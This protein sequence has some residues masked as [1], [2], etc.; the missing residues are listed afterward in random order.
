MNV[1]PLLSGLLPLLVLILLPASGFG[2]AP[3]ASSTPTGAR[4]LTLGTWTGSIALPG[5]SSLPVTYRIGDTDGA[6]SVV[7]NHEQLGDVP[8]S[9]ARFDGDELTFWWEPGIRVDCSLQWKEDGSMVGICTDG[10]GP[11]GQGTLTMMPPSG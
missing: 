9:D 4:D 6:L 1:R 11:A 10:S 8:F 5:G 2:Q 3:G 7:M